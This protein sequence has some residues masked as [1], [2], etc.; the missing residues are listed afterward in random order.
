MQIKFLGGIKFPF[1]RNLVPGY[2]MSYKKHHFLNKKITKQAVGVLTFFRC[3]SG[4]RVWCK[5]N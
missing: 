5:I 2:S 4:L 3:I 1:I